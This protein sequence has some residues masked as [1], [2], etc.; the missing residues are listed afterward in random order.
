MRMVILLARRR[1]RIEYKVE[2]RKSSLNTFPSTVSSTA[3]YPA[4]MGIV[5]RN[6]REHLTWQLA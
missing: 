1:K 4:Y 2:M 6:A 5:T 3:L